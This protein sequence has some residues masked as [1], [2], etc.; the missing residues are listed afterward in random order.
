MEEKTTLKSVDSATLRITNE[1]NSSR[2]ADIE[3]T[4]TVA[5]SSVN[6]V[7]GG[8]VCTGGRQVASFECWGDSNL[9][10]TYH[11]TAA[12]TMTAVCAAV[13]GFIADLRE[14]FTNDPFNV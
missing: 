14:R 9:H 3:A 8:T 12:D 5:G 2:T 11:S 4:A 1:N 13:S 10:I 7:N 6:S